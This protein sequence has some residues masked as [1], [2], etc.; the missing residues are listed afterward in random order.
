MQFPAQR[1]QQGR[2]LVFQ[3]EHGR[4]GKIRRVLEALLGESVCWQE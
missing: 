4:P 3:E 2:V 1:V